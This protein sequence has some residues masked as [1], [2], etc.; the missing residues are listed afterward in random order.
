MNLKSFPFK[1]CISHT[2]NSPIPNC[3][4]PNKQDWEASEEVRTSEWQDDW[5]NDDVSDAFSQQIKAELDKIEE[6]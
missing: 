1:V 4:C 3:K 6:K 2:K 5:D